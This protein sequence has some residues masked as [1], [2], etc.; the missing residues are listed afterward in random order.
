[1][2]SAI[3]SATTIAFDQSELSLANSYASYTT[4][5]GFYSLV[6]S[7]SRVFSFP[8][9]SVYSNSHVFFSQASWA[10]E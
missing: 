1:V 9:Y 10:D 5:D 3:T 6:T 4:Y 2:G 7:G 8:A